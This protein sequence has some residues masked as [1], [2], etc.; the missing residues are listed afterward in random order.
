MMVRL[1]LNW[2]RARPATKMENAILRSFYTLSLVVL[3][4]VA[5]DMAAV[6]WR[7]H[8][9]WEVVASLGSAFFPLIAVHE[10]RER[11]LLSWPW[12]IALIIPGVA[13][14]LMQL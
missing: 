7:K 14:G 6:A 10:L 3:P 1:P 2:L 8:R 13:L 12:I 4:F 11:D 9:W 5:I